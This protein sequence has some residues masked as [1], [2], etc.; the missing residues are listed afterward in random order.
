MI[1]FKSAYLVCADGTPKNEK[2]LGAKQR[3]LSFSWSGNRQ[4]PVLLH[5]AM[6]RVRVVRIH[7]FSL[8]N[9]KKISQVFVAP[10]LPAIFYSDL[11]MISVVS[12]LVVV[13]K[14]SN[15]SQAETAC[16][17]RPETSNWRN[18]HLP[19][20]PVLVTPAA[21]VRRSSFDGQFKSSLDGFLT[22]VDL[23]GKSLVNCKMQKAASAKSTW[24]T[25]TY[26][27]YS[28]STVVNPLGLV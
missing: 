10:G 27:L 25:W 18:R 1:Q 4:A 19:R 9:V 7:R 20:P 26:N 21:I 12:I 15:M 17:L 8:R 5:L 22:E 11:V 14:A 16:L 13:T 28:A 24:I 23:T 3:S 2:I 6:P